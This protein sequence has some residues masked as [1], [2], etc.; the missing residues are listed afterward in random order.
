MAVITG[1]NYVKRC[2]ILPLLFHCPIVPLPYKQQ[3]GRVT[4][5]YGLFLACG[6]RA[7][8]EL[9]RITRKQEAKSK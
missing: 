9:V 8:T 5:R 3:Q 2:L 6:R 1:F 4:F 7:S